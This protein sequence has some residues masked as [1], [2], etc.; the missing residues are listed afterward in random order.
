[1]RSRNV[2]NFDFSPKKAALPRLLQMA[3]SW[4]FHNNVIILRVKSKLEMQLDE[5]KKKKKKTTYCFIWVTF[6]TVGIFC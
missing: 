5:K 4:C 2:S 1:M 3:I 6:V